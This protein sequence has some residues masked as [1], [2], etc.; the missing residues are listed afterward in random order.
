MASTSLLCRLT[1]RSPSVPR[2]H[3]QMLAITDPTEK[4]LEVLATI[5][6]IG[7]EDINERLTVADRAWLLRRA[8]DFLIVMRIVRD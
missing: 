4:G 5:A 6:H 1:F 7:T 2:V 8:M 3:H